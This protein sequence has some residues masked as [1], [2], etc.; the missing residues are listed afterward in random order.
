MSKQSE[1]DAE[2]AESIKALRS[3]GVKPG[4]KVYTSVVHVAR[5]GM[6]RHIRVF[7]VKRGDVSD[8]TWHVARVLGMRRANDGGLV[9]GG[10]GMDMCFHTVYCLG[11]AMFPKGGNLKHSPRRAQEEREGATREIDGGYLLRNCSL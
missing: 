9:V 5:S 11:R 10:C 4:A 3:M 2:R 6:S 8:V 1:R 7:L